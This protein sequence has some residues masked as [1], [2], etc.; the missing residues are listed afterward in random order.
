MCRTLHFIYLRAF[1]NTWTILLICGDL[2]AMSLC[3]W[4]T[5]QY[6]NFVSSANF[7]ILLTICSSMSFIYTIK[8][9]WSQP[10]RTDP[11]VTP[12]STKFQS[13]HCPFN[14]TLCCL[15]YNQ[16][17]I[18]CKTFPRNPCACNFE[19]SLL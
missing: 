2:T 12:L 16:F 8:Q 7:K 3:P 10:P 5:V 19:I 4:V 6:D 9:E 15:P 13:E 14:T 11:W 18:H 1:A 17:S